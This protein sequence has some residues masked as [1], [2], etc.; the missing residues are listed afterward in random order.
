MFGFEPEEGDVY[1]K[2]WKWEARQRTLRI[3]KTPVVSNPAKKSKIRDPEQDA[4]I[5][6]KG[7]DEVDAVDGHVDE[8]SKTRDPEQDAHK[9]HD[10]V[11]AMDGNVDGD[12][13]TF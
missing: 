7:H 4:M 8:K 3:L 2:W 1:H 12:K 9:G 5:E 11:D 6:N 13:S 10:E